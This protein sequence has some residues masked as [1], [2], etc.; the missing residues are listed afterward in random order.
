MNVKLI[1]PD[2]RKLMIVEWI[3]AHTLDGS[4]V[5]LSGHAP[6]LWQLE[7]N[8][9]ISFGLVGGAVK[10]M[11]ITGGILRVERESVTVILSE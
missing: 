6:A 8:K 10:S 9:T 3:D 11:V 5:I 4:R 7:A 2:S 1:A